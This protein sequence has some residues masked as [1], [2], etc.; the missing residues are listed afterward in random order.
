M[1]GIITSISTR[2]KPP[3]RVAHRLLT[4]MREGDMMPVGFEKAGNHR[5][6]DFVILGNEDIEMDGRLMMPMLVPPALCSVL[7]SQRKAAC[8]D[9]A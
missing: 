6:I 1:P 5:T 4:I 2:S 7:I 3:S 8:T 9:A